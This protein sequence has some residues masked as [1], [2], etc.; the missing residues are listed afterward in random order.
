MPTTGDDKIDNIAQHL[1]ISRSRK[2]DRN[3]TCRSFG[4]QKMSRHFD[5]KEKTYIFAA[6]K[7]L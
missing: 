4:T 5:M 6:K 1:S 3:V 7:G 2:N